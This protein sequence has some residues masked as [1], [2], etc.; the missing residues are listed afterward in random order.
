[1]RGKIL[2]LFSFWLV[3]LLIIC[4]MGSSSALSYSGGGDWDYYREILISENSGMTLRG[5]QILVELNPTNFPSKINPDGS[6]LRFEEDGMEL[7]YWIEEIDIEKKTAKIWVKVPKI[8]SNGKAKI[9]MYYGNPSA[10]PMSNP[11]KTFDFW[12]SFENG[13]LGDWDKTKNGGNILKAKKYEGNYSVYVQD[14]GGSVS[15]AGG[16]GAIFSPDLPPHLFENKKFEFSY[17]LDKW[18]NDGDN[19]GEGAYITLLAYNSLGNVEWIVNYLLCW[20]DAND[21]SSGAHT[22]SG[23]YS[24]TMTPKG[25]RTVYFCDFLDEHNCEPEPMGKWHYH[26][27]SIPEDM[28][29]GSKEDWRDIDHIRI[30]MGATGRDTSGIDIR[31]FVD[32]I[33]TRTYA[34]IEPTITLSEEYFTV[35]DPLNITKIANPPSIN[36]GKTTNIKITV[37]NI[38]P[39]DIEDIKVMDTLSSDFN[40]VDGETSSKYNNLK[41]GESRTFEYTIEPKR[42]GKFD[43]G[44]ATA[45]YAYEGG[46]YHTVESNSLIVEVLPPLEG[47]IPGFEAVFAISGLLGVAYLI[48]RRGG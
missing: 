29:L 30:E 17:L 1:M 22:E 32:F 46:N 18:E 37:E 8:P 36:E 2:K 11:E 14:Q 48:R 9:N 41:S 21:P 39:L 47:G 4:G 24:V 42:E 10:I 45:T 34:S 26:S 20:D 25:Y 15:G 5:Y 28:P 12:E 19:N 27:R 7:K 33:K 3:V 13:D 6:D 31:Y 23:Q 16:E 43:L 38:G 40:L 44:Q 35:P